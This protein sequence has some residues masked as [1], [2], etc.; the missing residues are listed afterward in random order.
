MEL[1]VENEAKQS[2]EHGPENGKPKF[3]QTKLR[4]DNGGSA[5]VDCHIYRRRNKYLQRRLA[6]ENT[7]KTEY[8]EKYK[9]ELNLNSISKTFSRYLPY[10]NRDVKLSVGFRLDTSF[11]SVLRPKR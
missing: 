8:L 1:R 10:I 9:T 3:N 4:T 7:K 11:L 2:C 6:P 5:G